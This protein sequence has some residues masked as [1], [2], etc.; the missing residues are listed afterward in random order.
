MSLAE[1]DGQP[2]SEGIPDDPDQYPRIPGPHPRR[3]S[4]AHIGLVFAG[5][6]LGTAGR[7][8]LGILVPRIGDFPW[9]VFV[10]N[11]AGAFLLGWL[12]AGLSRSRSRSTNTTNWRLF[13]GTG[14]LGGFTTYSALALDTTVFLAWGA[15]G[16]ALSYGLLTLVLG[17]GATLAGIA[18][19]SMHHRRGAEAQS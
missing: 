12:L 1:G 14:F 16:L 5:G 4:P 15:V 3:L 2:P 18:V 10:A 17:G 9:A 8:G 7:E 13:L 6:T 11:L 19:A